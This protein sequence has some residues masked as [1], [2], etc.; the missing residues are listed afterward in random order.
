MRISFVAVFPEQLPRKDIFLVHKNLIFH[1]WNFAL[2]FYDVWTGC[3][4]S[5]CISGGHFE[6]LFSI[7]T[8]V[9]SILNAAPIHPADIQDWYEKSSLHTFRSGRLRSCTESFAPHKKQWIFITHCTTD[10]HFCQWN[11]G[12]INLDWIK[13]DLC[14]CSLITRFVIYSSFITLEGGE[15]YS[16]GIQKFCEVI[17]GEN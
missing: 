1:N 5:D 7:R 9:L 14:D 3:S 15:G 16:R 2:A 6:V 12:R 4:W 11:P 10:L 8:V 17:Q 13:T